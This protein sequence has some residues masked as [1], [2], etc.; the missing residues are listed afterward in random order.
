LSRQADL[1][2]L[3]AHDDL[4][5]VQ[6]THNA[7]DDN[8]TTARK[9]GDIDNAEQH[10][11]DLENKRHNM[12]VAWVTARHVQRVRAVDTIPPPPFPD[13][14]FFE[15]KD[16]CG[17]PAFNWGKWIAYVRSRLLNQDTWIIQDRNFYTGLTNLRRN[18]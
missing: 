9:D 3:E 14:S 7:N 13:D 1:D 18:I 15:E 17:F 5:R 11:Q 8:E 10:V 2:F 12:R 16:D 6:D 4:V